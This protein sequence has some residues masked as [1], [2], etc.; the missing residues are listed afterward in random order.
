MPLEYADRAPIERQATLLAFYDEMPEAS[1]RTV[2][3]RSDLDPDDAE[4]E[5]NVPRRYGLPTSIPLT[6]ST[7][8]GQ[9]RTR[10]FVARC[11]FTTNATGATR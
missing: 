6:T 10:R 8:L 3:R 5:S 4:P 11:A 9:G 7:R 2:S 1:G